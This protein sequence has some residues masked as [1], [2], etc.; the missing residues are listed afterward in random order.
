MT[1]NNNWQIGILDFDFGLNCLLKAEKMSRQDGEAIMTKWKHSN[2]AFKSGDIVFMIPYYVK[3][4]ELDG[5]EFSMI[6]AF[7]VV[8]QTYYDM[9]LCVFRPLLSKKDIV[10]AELK[11]G[12]SFEEW[13]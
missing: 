7:S 10:E 13:T 11:Y 6:R 5:Y 12:I 1:M 2:K 8:H 9:P 4:L 3:E